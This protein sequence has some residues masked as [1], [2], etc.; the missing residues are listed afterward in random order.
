MSSRRY[1]RYWQNKDKNICN[2]VKDRK[3]KQDC[4]M[5]NWKI[6]FVNSDQSSLKC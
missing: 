5:Y 4:I 2:I 3:E 6:N 1:V